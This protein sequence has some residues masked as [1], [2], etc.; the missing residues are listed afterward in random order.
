MET[1][2]FQETLTAV[3]SC[4]ELEVRIRQLQTQAEPFLAQ[5]KQ[6]EKEAEPHRLVMLENMA[7]GSQFASGDVLFTKT[8]GRRMAVI[9]AEGLFEL[10]KKERER[11]F[12]LVKVAVTETRKYIPE[13]LLRGISQEVPGSPQLKVEIVPGIGA[14]M[15]MAQPAAQKTSKTS[16]RGRSIEL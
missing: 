15:P 5:I 1:S 14:R 2:K 7:E 12:Q 8:P 11:F 4:A 9:S 3:K 16:A 6:L 13:H 10:L